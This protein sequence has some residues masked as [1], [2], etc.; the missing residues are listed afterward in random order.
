[1]KVY[2]LLK[3]IF[4]STLLIIKQ[5]QFNLL[6]THHLKQ[7]NHYQHFL[8][9]LRIETKRNGEINTSL[10]VKLDTVIIQL[11]T[12]CASL[13]F[14]ILKGALIRRVCLFEGVCL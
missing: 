7:P 1:M 13:I 6:Y 3:N 14:S 10:Q 4:M 12:R 5:K 9:Y 11:S 2:N 8:L